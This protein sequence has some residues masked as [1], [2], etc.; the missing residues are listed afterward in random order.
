[1]QTAKDYL[2]YTAFSKSGLIK[3]LKFDKYS[4]ADATFAVNHIEVDW[5]EQA[6]KTA[7]DY[8]DYSSFSRQGLIDQ[9]KFDGYTQEEATYGVDK[10]GL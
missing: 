7:Q 5:K 2:D 8:M 1:M 9:L 4:T 3:Q 6:V 10:V